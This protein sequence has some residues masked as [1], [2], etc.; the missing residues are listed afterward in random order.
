MVSGGSFSE[1]DRMTVYTGEPYEPAPI[2]VWAQA[3][4]FQRNYDI[5]RDVDYSVSYENNIL[6][7]KGE[8]VITG[9]GE[10]EGE[11]RYNYFDKLDF[12]IIPARAEITSV[13]PGQGKLRV[14][15][16][17]Q[18]DSGA[19]GYVVTYKESGSEKTNTVTVGAKADHAMI[20]GLEAGKK[21]EVSL[22]AFVTIDEEVDYDYET[23]SYFGGP[24][25]YF[26]EESEAVTSG[27]VLEG[28]SF[29]DVK[30]GQFFYDPV[31]WAVKND[32]TSGTSDSEFSPEKDC[33][34]AEAVTFLW[35]ANCCE[36]VL[37]PSNPFIDVKDTD[38]YNNAVIWA[39]DKEITSG[40]SESTFG[41]KEK[42]KRNQI[43]T[44][45]WRAA[46][47]PEATAEVDFTDVPENAYYYQAV[48]WAVEKGITKGID[49]SNFGP[50]DYCTRGQIVTL[51]YRAMG[52]PDQ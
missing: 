13:T 18:K 47:K 15:F 8:A 1:K 40:T 2:D 3:P 31:N 42:C 9:I 32:I 51:L 37:Y 50:D 27:A 12:N 16:K 41:P 36:K 21:Y 38:Y 17:S 33:T 24:T 23:D 29:T 39:N 44:F 35:R 52:D 5:V 43:V 14:D 46:G 4:G 48:Q 26:G 49:D 19:D 6:C 45:L 22:K 25:D 10:Y 34:R 20:F 30:K 7:G 11:V 28:E